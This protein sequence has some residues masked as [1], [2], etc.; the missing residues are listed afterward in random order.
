MM[1]GAS[2]LR[3]GLALDAFAAATEA[4]FSLTLTFTYSSAVYGSGD[5][6]WRVVLAGCG[7]HAGFTVGE[8]GG[9]WK[10]RARRR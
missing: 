4:A 5:G 3:W 7:G 6:F 2:V 9:G 1:Q 10:P 8:R